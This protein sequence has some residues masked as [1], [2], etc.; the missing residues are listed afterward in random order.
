MKNINF[1]RARNIIIMV[2]LIFVALLVALSSIRSCKREQ[3]SGMVVLENA[4]QHLLSPYIRDYRNTFDDITYYVDENGNIVIEDE[5]GNKY[6]VR[7]D[8][9]VWKVNDDGSL[10]QVD[11]DEKAR[12]LSRL[13]QISLKDDSISSLLNERDLDRNLDLTHLSDKEIEKMAG[14]LGVDETELKRLIEEAK[15]RGESLTFE[16]VK[17]VAEESRTAEE[18]VKKLELQALKDYLDTLGITDITPE[19]LLEAINSSGLTFDDFMKIALEKGIGQALKEVGL[20]SVDIQ[21]DKTPIIQLPPNIKESNPYDDAIKRLTGDLGTTPDIDFS[22]LQE[23]D[24]Y[25]ALNNQKGKQDWL[26]DKQKGTTVLRKKKISNNMITNGTVINGM[27]LTAINTDIPGTIVAIVRENV[28][29]SFTHSNILIPKGS[30]LIASYDSSVS[31]GQT[32]ILVAWEQLIRTDGTII[33][34]NGYQGTG[35]L[36]ESGTAGNVNNHIGTIIGASVLSSVINFG[37]GLAGS[38]MDDAG[39]GRLVNAISSGAGNSVR[40]VSDRFLQKAIDRQPTITV[41]A[42][43]KITII[44]NDNVELPIWE[45]IKGVSWKDYTN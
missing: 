1:K 32:R 18:M 20:H 40:T 38:L 2:L 29:D 12:I 45:K 10:V 43:S 5:N 31:W 44:T 36:G 3:Q 22:A 21:D 9:T 35:K 4:P 6:I 8:G 39:W 23:V 16:E 19:E 13:K 15:E 37:T 14:I 42:G 7:P 11:G 27:L 34:L 25:S 24:S 17:S 41:N 28:Y 33:Q 26:K 30:K